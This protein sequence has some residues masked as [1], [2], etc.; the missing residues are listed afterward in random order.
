MNITVLNSSPYVACNS[1][2]TCAAACA[3]A[4]IPADPAA[5]LDGTTGSSQIA[6]IDSGVFVWR[7]MMK[8]GN[9]MDVPSVMGRLMS[10]RMQA[11]TIVVPMGSLRLDELRGPLVVAGWISIRGCSV[12]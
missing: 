7:E 4:K 1:A 12:A 3:A 10:Q 6:D 11:A 2:S 5:T 8:K 9:I